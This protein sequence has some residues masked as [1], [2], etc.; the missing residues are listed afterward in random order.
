MAGAKS[1]ELTIIPIQLAFDGSTAA[2]TGRKPIEAT[3]D[4]AEH[5][6][7]SRCSDRRRAEGTLTWTSSHQRLD[8]FSR[9]RRSIYFSCST[10]SLFISELWVALLDNP[11]QY[12]APLALLFRS[13]VQR[14]TPQLYTHLA[15]MT[16]GPCN[17]TVPW[18]S[19]YLMS[20]KALNEGGPYIFFLR[21]CACVRF[22]GECISHSYY[23]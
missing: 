8:S 22:N 12:T 2:A 18:Y 23:T 4:I 16:R 5:C 13:M 1:L 9:Y 3:R 10:Q 14:S 20:L 21:C 11:L 15:Q 19:G 17:I 7:S 6:H